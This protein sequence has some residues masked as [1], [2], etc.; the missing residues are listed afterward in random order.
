M[1]FI[2]MHSVLDGRKA[3]LGGVVPLLEPS[4]R[5]WPLSLPEDEGISPYI[6]TAGGGQDSLC[7]ELF[8]AALATGIPLHSD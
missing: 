3:F 1:S 6:R 8:Q 4:D 7:G 2:S 5:S